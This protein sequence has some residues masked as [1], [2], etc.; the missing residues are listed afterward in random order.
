MC[1]VVF[2][3]MHW[4]PSKWLCL[5]RRAGTGTVPAWSVL[6]P[7]VVLFDE[8]NCMV[9]C[10]VAETGNPLCATLFDVAETDNPLCAT[11]FAMSQSVIAGDL[12]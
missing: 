4:E 10:C 5:G 3:W 9:Q 8:K 12:P 7:R 1:A 2:G 6:L 11:L